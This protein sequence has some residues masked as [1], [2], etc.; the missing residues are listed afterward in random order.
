MLNA[1][2]GIIYD[3]PHQGRD[4][5]LAWFHDTHMPEKLARP[6]YE[7]AAHYEVINSSGNHVSSLGDACDGGTGLGYVALFWGRDTQVFLNPSPAQIKPHQPPLTRQMMGLRIGQRSFIAAQEW[8]AEFDSTPASADTPFSSSS[9]AIPLTG[10]KRSAPGVC[11][12]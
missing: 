1:I 6:G 11:R 5:Y 9:C 7:W 10:T 2:W 4:D 3:L 8:Y 12:N